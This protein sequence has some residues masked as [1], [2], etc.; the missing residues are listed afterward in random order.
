MISRSRVN[1]VL[2][3]EVAETPSADCKNW[4]RDWGFIAMLLWLDL[5]EIQLDPH[6]PGCG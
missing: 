6:R 3:S 2:K 5:R 4:R 1:H